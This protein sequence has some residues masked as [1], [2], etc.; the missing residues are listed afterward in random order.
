MEKKFNFDFPHE[1]LPIENL[2]DFSNTL[3]QNIKYKFIPLKIYYKY[4]AYKYAK[5]TTPELNIISTIS[6]KTKVSLDIGAN[7]GLFTYFMSRCSKKVFAFEPNPYPL[8]YL[9]YVVDDNVEIVPIAVGNLDGITQLRIPK[10][11]KGW[12]SNGASITNVELNQGI[13]YDVSI[14]KIDT[15]EIE[16]IGLIKIDVEGAELEVLNGALNTLNTQKPNLIIENELVHSDKPEILFKFMKKINYN[17]FYVDENKD[18][19]KLEDN[20]DVLKNQNKPANKRFG[21]IQNFIFMH[22]ERL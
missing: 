2:R 16:N 6:D 1:D 22:D 10:N 15:L 18:L 3:K 8:R 5:N 19:K 4:R 17:A 13:E 9:K 20:F 11:R 21:Y 14:H 12:S 7:L